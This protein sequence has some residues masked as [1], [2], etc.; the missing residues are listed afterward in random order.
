MLE[1]YSFY[2]PGERAGN[3]HRS[4]SVIKSSQQRRIF[5]EY[6]TKTPDG[7]YRQ[8]LLTYL[9]PKIIKNSNW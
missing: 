8:G 3:L 7:A 5:E 2:I 1:V 6:K 4:F 9:F